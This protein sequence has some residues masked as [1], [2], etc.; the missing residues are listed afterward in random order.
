MT[1][2][3]GLG[4]FVFAGVAL[5]LSGY[6]AFAA[7]RGDLG[8]L[9][10]LSIAAE[11]EALEAERDRLAFEVAVMRNLTQRLSD[12]YLDLDLLDERARDTLGW[13][14]PDELVVR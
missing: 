13:I 5:A 8:V 11:L 7:V 10:R 14:R 1:Q 6:F 12:S 4:F 2:S 9:E 3:S